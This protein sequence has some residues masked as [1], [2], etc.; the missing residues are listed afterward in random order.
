MTDPTRDL[1]V[2]CSALSNAKP[3]G[4]WRGVRVK[5]ISSD[6]RTVKRGEV[7]VCLK[8]ARHD[9]HAFVLKAVRDGAVAV[10]AERPLRPAVPLILVPDARRAMAEMAA[11]FWEYPSRRLDVIGITGTNGKTTTAH[12]LEGILRAAGVRTALFGTVEYRFGG[13]SF[14]H[15]HT[16]D[17]APVLQRLFHVVRQRGG[18]AVVMEASSEG[19]SQRRVVGTQF[20]A[21][22]FTNLSRDHLNFHRTMRR[23][24]E[25]KVALFE[26]LPPGEVGGV[27][28][29]N[30]DSPWGREVA[31]RTRGRL[32]R[33]GFGTGGETR[34]PCVRGAAVRVS[35]RGTRLM[36][37]VGG[38]RM[39]V[40][41]KLIGAH[42]AANA[43]AAAAAAW[44]MGVEPPDIRRGL[45]GVARVPGRLESVDLGA[46]F[47][48]LVDYAHTPDA[49]DRVLKAVGALTRR[50]LIT[51]VGCGGNRD[52]GKRPVMARIATER[53]DL[54]LVTS[55]NPRY[56]DPL[57]IIREMV[58][59]I[60][61]R[62]SHVTEPDRRR[63][64]A[65]ALAEARS[66]DVV[67]VAGKGHERTQTIRGNAH[68]FDDVKVVR[69][70]W[71]R[72]SK[73]R[74]IPE[75]R[76]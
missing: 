22:V 74:R 46:P 19:M 76:T 3:R 10:V 23:Y 69:Q 67:V 39:A 49:L 47:T 35:T 27:A 17:E 55:D 73:T 2:L 8:G 42:N 43:L 75:V 59:G 26:G 30:S 45:E 36:M 44:G 72:L 48:V 21:G 52:R 53:S 62:G 34:E 37:N 28:A 71:A 11:A 15:A 13:R 61:R 20:R 57:S 54:A 66:G 5:G 70:E 14:R 9:G 6:S 56:E 31:R 64:I 40:S 29:V 33:H 63:A 25:A 60:R 50:R 65:R 24:F 4:R 58:E 38:H 7:F 18:A 16:T 41:L 68:P 12:M 1:A 51:V 32:V